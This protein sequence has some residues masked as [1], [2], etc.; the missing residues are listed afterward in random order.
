MHDALFMDVVHLMLK[1]ENT[2][3][4]KTFENLEIGLADEKD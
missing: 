3:H 4:I 2:D 1:E